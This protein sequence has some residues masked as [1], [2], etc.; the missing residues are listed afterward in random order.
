MNKYKVG[1]VLYMIGDK[2]TSIIPIQIVEEVV[3]TTPASCPIT[4]LP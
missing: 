1:Q 2:T 4:T 3:R